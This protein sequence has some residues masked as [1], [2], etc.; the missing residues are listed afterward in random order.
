MKTNATQNEIK[1]EMGIL[2]YWDNK[3]NLCS[4]QIFSQSIADA[5]E[6]VASGFNVGAPKFCQVL[7]WNAAAINL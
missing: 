2:T 7:P 1:I 3:A 6:I 4:Y 5:M